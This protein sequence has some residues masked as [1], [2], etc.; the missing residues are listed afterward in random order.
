[1]LSPCYSLTSETDQSP[2]VALQHIPVQTTRKTYR[3]TVYKMILEY[4]TIL[5]VREKTQIM[6]YTNRIYKHG[7]SIYTFSM[8]SR[9]PHRPMD[10]TGSTE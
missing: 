1:M 8:K 9:A 7:L 3:K 5:D 10:N 2:F 6:Q 4:F